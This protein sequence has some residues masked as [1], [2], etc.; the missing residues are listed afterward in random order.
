MQ[1]KQDASVQNYLHSLEVPNSAAQPCLTGIRIT[2]MPCVYVRF[3]QECTAQPRLAWLGLLKEQRD[4]SAASA[5]SLRCCELDSSM[6]TN[7]LQGK[8]HNGSVGCF[9]CNNLTV[10]VRGLSSV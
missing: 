5:A 3:V 9:C 8:V 4:L 2:C 1:C 10:C 7:V 6:S